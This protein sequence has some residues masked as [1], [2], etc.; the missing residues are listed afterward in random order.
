MLDLLLYATLC[1]KDKI[2][3]NMRK[4]IRAFPNWV[5]GTMVTDDA[6]IMVI[7]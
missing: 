4:H 3:E 7:N 6:M 5:D 2:C 1:Q